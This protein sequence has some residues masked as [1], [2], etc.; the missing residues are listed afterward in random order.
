MMGGDQEHHPHHSGIRWL[1]VVVTVAIVVISVMSL[2]VS[3]NH[4][5][6]MERLVAENRKMVSATT[7]P[8]LE[9]DFQGVDPVTHR[10]VAAL[11]LSNDGVGPAIVEWVE[12]RLR[13]KP[14]P[15]SASLLRACCD[16]RDEH[17]TNGFVYSTPSARVLPAREKINVYWFDPMEHAARQTFV[18]FSAVQ[19]AVTYRGCYCSVLG[20]CWITNF[21][22]RRPTP[23]ERCTVSGVTP[24]R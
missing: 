6:T 15:D 7:L 18:K 3:I 14:M 16:V 4:G 13:G 8:Y 21:D 23:I 2:V 12:I 1:D 17:Q 9:M 19:R 5:M 24:F 20:D 11:V 10:R 22:G